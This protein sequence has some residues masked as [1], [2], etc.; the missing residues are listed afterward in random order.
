MEDTTKTG[1]AV[2]RRANGS[3]RLRNMSLT[4]PALAI[5]GGAAAMAFELR[6]GLFATALILGWTQLVGL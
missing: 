1:C 5:W 2:P 4:I 3:I 6:F